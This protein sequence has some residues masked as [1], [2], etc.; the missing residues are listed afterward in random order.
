MSDQQLRKLNKM[1]VIYDV[2]ATTG[3]YQKDGKTM[4]RNQ[5][6]G[7]V[8]ETAKGLSLKIDQIPLTEAGGWNGWAALFTP[9]TEEKQEEK[10]NRFTPQ[11]P[12]AKDLPD[13]DIP[14]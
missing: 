6:I 7:H 11:K 1:A 8:V 9:W 2:V 13:S 3:T 14:F 10:Q 4:Y 5:T 12:S